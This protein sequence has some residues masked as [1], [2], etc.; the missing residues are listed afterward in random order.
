MR[1][2]V[3]KPQEIFYKVVRYEVPAFQRRYI[4][5]KENQWEPR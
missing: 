5:T 1:T 4:W 3:L 2:D